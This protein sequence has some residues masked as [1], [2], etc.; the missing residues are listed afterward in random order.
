M[1]SKQSSRGMLPL[2]QALKGY[3]LEDKGGYITRESQDY[4][5]RLAMEL[6]DEKHKALYIKLA[7]TVDRKLL[8]KALSFVKDSGARSPAKLFMWKLK[9][10]Q[11]IGVAGGVVVW[12]IRSLLT[13]LPMVMLVDVTD[14]FFESVSDTF[15]LDYSHKR[16]KGPESYSFTVYRTV[17]ASFWMLLVYSL[18]VLVL[19]AFSVTWFWTLVFGVG[20]FGLILMLLVQEHHN[21]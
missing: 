4:W 13:S 18:I 16:A 1:S 17:L 15:Y 5:Y 12:L 3:K 21:R 11:V 7:K 10:F 2:G 6:N 19:I 8:E 20:A 14:K 9:Q